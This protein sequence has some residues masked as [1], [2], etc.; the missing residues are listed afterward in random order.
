MTPVG[1]AC[2]KAPPKLKIIF[3]WIW[4]QLEFRAATVS[5]ARSC[6]ALAAGR[7]CRSR[8]APRR[9]SASAPSSSWARSRGSRCAGDAGTTTAAAFEAAFA[10]LRARRREMSLYRPGERAG[11]RERARGRARRAGRCR[12]CSRCSA[13]ARELSVATDGAFDV[14]VLPLLRRGARIRD[15]LISAPAASTRSASAASRSTRRAHGAVPARGM[16]VDLG[17]IAKGFALDRARA[18]LVAAGVTRA[19]LDLG[20]SWRSSVPVRGLARRRARSGESGRAARRARRS[21]PTTT[22]STSGNY[23]RD[24]AAEGWRRAEPHLRSAHRTRRVGAGRAVTV[25]APD[26]TTADALSTGASGAR[27]RATRS[28]VLA[29]D[30]GAGALFVERAGAYVPRRARR[31]AA[32]ALAIPDG[33]RQSR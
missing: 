29:R 33:P 1:A 28:Q 20:G 25:W 18:A 32:V 21:T 4:T 7:R 22:V 23:A 30:A 6:C 8:G 19:R 15:S 17:G 31:P 27:A 3:N 12:R 10:A 13:R 14:T 5:A 11:A 26:A 24:F 2:Y 9:R 16:G